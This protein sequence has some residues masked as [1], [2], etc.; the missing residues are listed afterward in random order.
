LT[1]KSK[2]VE[3]L[4]KNWKEIKK[5]AG[6]SSS[7]FLVLDYDGTLSPIA[8]RPDKAKLPAE[9]KTLLIKLRTNPFFTLAIISGRSLKE[10]RNIVGI[11]GLIY[12]GNHGLE[13]KGTNIRYVNKDAISEREILHRLYEELRGELCVMGGVA[14]EDKGLT[15]TIH[16]RLLDDKDRDRFH[17]AVKALLDPWVAKKKIKVTRGK[18]IYE[19]RPAV[20][21]N[22]GS[23]VKWLLGQ[24]EIFKEK[25]LT[26]CLGDDH[27]DED[28]FKAVG[29]KGITACV[30]RDNP[31]SK[32]GYYL[33]DTA[34]V[35]KFLEK[36]TGL[37][38]SRK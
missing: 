5:R 23:T 15:L 20:N 36:L 18:M 19:A 11:P 1:L 24:K 37:T 10:I 35:A 21:W 8:S 6:K 38:G 32:A 9:T 2:R 31:F 33:E 22:K 17:A 34:E 4:L 27:T 13:L 16:Y 14:V 29:S 3:H 30:G 7:V 28:M 12:A 26:I 25:A